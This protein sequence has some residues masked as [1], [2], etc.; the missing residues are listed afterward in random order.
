VYS[1]DSGISL[2]W[3]DLLKRWGVN[4]FFGTNPFKIN[5]IERMLLFVLL[6]AG[7]H[8]NPL[9]TVGNHWK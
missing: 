4:P 7:F 6:F 1:I 3:N 5:H 9:E 2:K 8:W